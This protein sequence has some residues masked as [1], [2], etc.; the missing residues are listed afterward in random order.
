MRSR[1]YLVHIIEEQQYGLQ[2]EALDLVYLLC[3]NKQ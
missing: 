2:K 3:G 1:I